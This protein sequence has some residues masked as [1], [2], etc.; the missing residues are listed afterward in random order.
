[1]Q[2]RVETRVDTQEKKHRQVITVVGSLL[3]SHP[4]MYKG[5]IPVAYSDYLK[6]ISKSGEWGDHVTL[7]AAA[8][9][10]NNVVLGCLGLFPIAGAIISDSFYGSFPVIV[11]FSIVSL[12]DSD[13]S[14]EYLCSEVSETLVVTEDAKFKRK[15]RDVDG[16]AG[17]KEKNVKPEPML[18]RKNQQQNANLA[19][20]QVKTW[21][22]LLNTFCT[23]GKLEL[24]L[25]FTAYMSS[26]CHIELILSE[27]EEP[28][29]KEVNFILQLLEVHAQK[30]SLAT[31]MEDLQ[32]RASG[33]LDE[34]DESL[35]EKVLEE[36]K[37][38]KQEAM[39]NL[40]VHE[41]LMDR[42]HVV[43]MLQL[44]NQAWPD[45]KVKL[46]FVENLLGE[47]EKLMWQQWRTT[48]PIAYSALETIAD[49]PQNITSQNLE[50]FTMVMVRGFG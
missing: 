25:Y 31:A 39:E 33:M 16:P 49:D 48:Y 47:S 32:F 13:G 44:N 14:Y 24:T 9:L 22:E 35:M 20:R 34:G 10:V 42:R 15:G 8:D 38:L 7:Q 2:T 28:L 26:P 46:A 30:T 5:Y 50:Y 21:A 29:T 11:F 6:R 41:F 27:K 4:K 43:D 40:K 37:R 3:K 45:N 1:M 12:M 18:K 17:E 19:L 23:S 36:S